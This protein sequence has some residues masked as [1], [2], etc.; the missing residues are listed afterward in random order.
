[1]PHPKPATASR[2]RRPVADK[3]IRILVRPG[4]ALLDA[5]IKEVSAHDIGLLLDAALEAG[6][7]VAVLNRYASLTDSR[8][9][10]AR[11][12]YSVPDG[13]GGWLVY[14]RFSSPLSEREL[15]DFL[16]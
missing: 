16:D 15:K 6:T 14:C 10:S 7:V 5:G 4:L 2:P 12:A 11:V 8:I 3:D 13:R 1:M 9:L